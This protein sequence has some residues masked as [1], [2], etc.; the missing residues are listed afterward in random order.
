[1]SKTIPQSLVK[2]VLQIILKNLESIP[3]LINKIYEK[4]LVSEKKVIVF[5]KKCTTM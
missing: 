1:M 2:Y 4:Y 3:K 5:I